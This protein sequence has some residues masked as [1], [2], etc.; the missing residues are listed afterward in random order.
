MWVVYKDENSV[1]GR[2]PTTSAM[3]RVH[4]C[5]SPEIKEHMEKHGLR[6][7]KNRAYRVGISI[8]IWNTDIA[9]SELQK[10][11]NRKRA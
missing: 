2:Y 1:V 7:I 11:R 6:L 3:L 5:T 4:L 8:I 10:T 9:N